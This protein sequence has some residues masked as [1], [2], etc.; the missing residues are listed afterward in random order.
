VL[1]WFFVFNFIIIYYAIVQP[2]AVAISLSPAV[3]AE[4]P[5]FAETVIVLDVTPL[6]NPL[7]TSII[8]NLP[9]FLLAKFN[10]ALTFVKGALAIT[11]L[12]IVVSVV[13]EFKLSG[14]R[15]LKE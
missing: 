15:F 10:E 6:A 12:T 5:G 11:G 1:S 7:N 3:N 4:N 2:L 14:G 13:P 8:D 9:K